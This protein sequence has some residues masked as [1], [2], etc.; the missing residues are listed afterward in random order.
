[1][2]Q[3]RF[4]VNVL[5]DGAIFA[6]SPRWQGGSFWYSD[7]G[8][9][10]I[11]RLWPD[12]RSEV[13]LAGLDTPSGL[14]WL[15]DGDLVVACIRPSTVC[16]I[17]AKGQ[18]SVWFAP[19]D[20][21]TLA[22]NDMAT[23]GARS[24]V[25]CVGRHHEPGADGSALREPVGSILLLDH[26]QRRCSTVAAGLRLPNGVAIAP[27]GQSLLVS[28]MGAQ[29]ILRFPIEPDGTLGLAQEWTATPCSGDGIC[30]DAEGGVWVGSTEDYFLRIGPDGTET[31]RI[32]VPGWACVAPMLGGWDGRTLLMAAYQMD[33]IDAM[34]T[35][36]SR[37]R[38]FTARV[39]VPAAGF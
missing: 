1:M 20:H 4:K 11:R 26:A 34:F 36:G 30:L 25:T 32:E 21:G 35:G 5:H 29:R 8:A 33:D 16:R 18:A 37:S 12:G 7:I 14:G 22:L 13:F 9:G 19:E 15:P 17:G 31:A 23:A 38:L 24:Y 10:E 39:D 2:P 28:E 6:E 27:D 3:T